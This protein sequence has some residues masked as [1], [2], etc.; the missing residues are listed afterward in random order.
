MPIV[1]Q[2]HE[3]RGLA[4]P[5]RMMLEYAGIPYTNKYAENWRTGT[6]EKAQVAKVNAL[7]NLPALFDEDGVVVTQSCAVNFHV[8]EK[9]GLNGS[10]PA[11][12]SRVDQVRSVCLLLLWMLLCQ[13]QC[14]CHAFTR[15][16]YG[17]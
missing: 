4:S 9:V 14:Q 6:N 11:E 15:C 8:A 5:I 16:A 12:R 2:Y 17:L 1:L 3:I 7:A 13:C 10:T